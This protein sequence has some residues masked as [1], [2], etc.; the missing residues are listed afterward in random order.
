[1]QRDQLADPRPPPAVGRVGVLVNKLYDISMVIA[2][3][4][5]DGSLL[6]GFTQSQASTPK[7]LYSVENHQLTLLYALNLTT[8]AIEYIWP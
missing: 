2:A 3:Y 6:L 4:Q 1:M 8:A 7:S 5:E